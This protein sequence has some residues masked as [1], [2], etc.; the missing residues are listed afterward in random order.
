MA[1]KVN[2]LIKKPMASLVTNV[3]TTVVGGAAAVGASALINADF[4]QKQKDGTPR[5]IG[6]YAG[7]ILMGVGLAGN[8]FI[9]EPHLRSVNN[10]C[11]NVGSI[12]MTGN[13]IMPQHKAKLGLGDIAAPAATEDTYAEIVRKALAAPSNPNTEF[14]REEQVAGLSNNEGANDLVSQLM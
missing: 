3:T 5:K 7:L 4:V 12:H 13:V 8:C 2:I 1:T 11:F 6:K 9:E 14:A 10:A